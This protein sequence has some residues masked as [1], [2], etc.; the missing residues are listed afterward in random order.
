MAKFRYLN[1]NDDKVKRNDCVTRALTLASGLPYS[2]IRR[3][4]RYTAR[5]LDCSK[6]CVSCY[7]FFIE[8]VLLGKRTNCDGMTVEEFADLHPIGV[9]LV[10]MDGH[11]SVIIDNTIMDIFDCRQHLL[12]N[13]WEVR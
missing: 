12:T 3:K 6:L 4:L 11:I 1:V 8:E 13:A 9:F 2:S 7:S 10:R 5:L